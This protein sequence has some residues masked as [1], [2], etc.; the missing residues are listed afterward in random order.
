MLGNILFTIGGLFFA[1]LLIIIYFLRAKQTGVNNSLYKIILILIVPVIITKLIAIGCIFYYPEK[2]LLGNFFA[3]IHSVFIITWMI[4]ICCYL[5]NLEDRKNYTSLKEFLSVKEFRVL[6][7]LWIILI[8]ISFLLPFKNV[9]I[10]GEGAFMDGP[11]FKFLFISSA[12]YILSSF[13]ITQKKGNDL[14]EKNKKTLLVGFVVTVTCLLIQIIL[15]MV[16]LTTSIL[17]FYIYLLYFSFENPDLYLIK[18]LETAKNRAEKSNRAKT[19]FLSNMSHE[20]RTPMN[21]I[22]G[23][24]EGILNEEEFDE[25]FVKKDIAH[26]YAAGSNLLEIINNILDISKIETGEDKLEEKEYSIGSVVLELKSIIESRLSNG[27]I[28]FI[29]KTDPN[30]PAKLYG[31]KT[32]VFQVLLNI[33]SNAVKYTEVG[34]INLVIDS[35]IK[36]DNQVLLKV[37]ISDTGYGIRKEDYEK[38]FEKFS[39]LDSATRNEIEG[40]GLGLVITK[41]LVNLMG[42]KIWFESEYGAGT[43]FFIEL[44]QK[45]VDKT[46]IGNIMLENTITEGHDYLDCNGFKVLIVDDNKL[47]LMVASKVLSPYNFTIK[48]LNDGRDCVNHI[49]EGNEYDIIFLDHMMPHMD[50]IEV[51]HIL[52]KLEG[53]N[54]PP[55]VALTANA[56]TG[57]KEMYLGEGFD[58]YLPKPINISDL[59]KLINKYFAN[60]A[61]NK[62]TTKTIEKEPLK[63]E[64]KESIE[65]P[66]E[67]ATDKSSNE[68]RVHILTDNGIDV[69][70][71]LSFVGNMENYNDM[72]REFYDEVDDKINQLK[73]SKEENDMPNYAIVV[74]SLKSDCRFLGINNFADQAYEQ[75][76]KSKEGNIEFINEHYYDLVI[77]KNK[78]KEI[79]KKYFQL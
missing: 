36:N 49:K 34:R 17:V 7:I 15:P 64:I 23:F 57:S 14:I 20:I 61:K 58:E 73:E 22:I 5:I 47:N 59:D 46:P 43:S 6:S 27:K 42:G 76:M 79:I 71:A 33:L 40:T 48:T 10:P 25:T 62:K 26:I 70:G 53:Y 2:V 18:D 11:A 21:A 12:I 78:T 50:G 72:L 38:L 16:L 30:I 4:S 8:I 55:I 44:T 3:H 29:T 41:R 28:K 39:R 54:I 63:E 67:E 32:K 51:L 69:Q 1:L 75:E 35:Q 19:E 13:S 9:C 52:H 74:H 65:S 37:K 56:V 77:S 31:D 66:S 45:I 60:K 24:S 68:D